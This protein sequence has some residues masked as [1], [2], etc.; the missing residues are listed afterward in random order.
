MKLRC[1]D[2]DMALV[3]HDTVECAANIGRLVRVH[4]P[5][6]KSFLDE[7]M[8][9]WRISQL[10]AE[11]WLIHE[12][13]GSVTSEIVTLVSRVFHR[14]EWLMPIR[15]EVT[16]ESVAASCTQTVLETTEVTA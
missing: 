6:R 11:P 7:S 12:E 3:I 4:G 15:L 13:D 16:D 14:D 2:G 10:D 1:K 5:T 9:C 8:Q